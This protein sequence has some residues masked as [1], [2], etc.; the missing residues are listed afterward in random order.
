VVA[1]VFLMTNP[2]TSAQEELLKAGMVYVYPQYINSCPNAMPFKTA[3]SIAREGKI[4]L[5][6]RNDQRPWD[7]RKTQRGN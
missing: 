2:E 7:Y 4:G 3:E 5:W 6:A 1:E